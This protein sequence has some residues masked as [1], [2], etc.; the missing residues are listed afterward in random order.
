MLKL[1]YIKIPMN[2][3]TVEEKNKMMELENYEKQK[4]KNEKKIRGAY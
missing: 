2:Q 1:L 4:M 3:L